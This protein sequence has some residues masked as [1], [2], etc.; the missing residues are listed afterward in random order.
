MEHVK[1]I[2]NTRGLPSLT[3]AKSRAKS[4]V[5][6]RVCRSALSRLMSYWKD[7]TR[8][9]LMSL[10]CEAVGGDPKLT[11]EISASLILLAAGIDIHDDIIDK[12]LVKDYGETVLG[13][14]GPEITLLVGDM[15]FV[16]GLTAIASSLVSRGFPDNKIK[17]ILALVEKLFL[18]LSDAEAGELRLRRRTDITPRSYLRLTRL[19]AADV[20]A[21]LKIG[22]ILGGG[23]TVETEALGRYGRSLGMIVILRDDLSDLLDFEEELPHRIEYEHL[24]LPILYAVKNSEYEKKIVS[25][26]HKSKIREEDAEK[27][28]KITHEA[29]GLV[30]YEKLMKRLVYTCRR[31]LNRLPPSE[32]RSTLRDV[33]DVTAPPP[34][35]DLEF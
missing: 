31:E 10:A 19:K 8:P 23:S 13:A 17:T 32:A 34:L 24:P 27:L 4:G 18:E 25:L 35:S 15:L 28:L 1:N 2:F 29:G 5:S 33:V 30:S 6:D 21:Y 20:E 12:S 16:K 3:L 11:E 26:L 14:R 22:S 9:A 7:Y